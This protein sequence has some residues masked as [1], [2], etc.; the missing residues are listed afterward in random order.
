MRNLTAS[1]DSNPKA[2]CDARGLLI[3][4]LVTAIRVWR[5]AIADNLQALENPLNSPADLA[6]YRRRCEE[7]EQH[8]LALLPEEESN[9]H[10]T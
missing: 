9:N 5:Q 10:D 4:R 6:R 1:P 7:A 8:L 3:D 2:E